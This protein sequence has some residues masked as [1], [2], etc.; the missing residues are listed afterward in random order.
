M[1]HGISNF[2]DSPITACSYQPLATVMHGFMYQA[3]DIPAFPGCP[4]FALATLTSFEYCRPYGLE[5]GF[6]AIQ[7]NSNIH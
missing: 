3:L 7:Y 4:Y 1:Q 2:L 5:T 6:F